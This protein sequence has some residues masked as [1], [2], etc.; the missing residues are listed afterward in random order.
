MSWLDEQNMSEQEKYF[1]RRNDLEI[2]RNQ[3]ALFRFFLKLL[4][5]FFGGMVL[6]GLI[7]FIG[8]H[9]Y[10]FTGAIGGFLGSKIAKKIDKNKD[11]SLN[12]RIIIYLVF[13][14]IFGFIFSWSGLL[15]KSLFFPNVAL[16]LDLYLQSCKEMFISIKNYF[17]DF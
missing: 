6:I 4:P 12:K 17:A 1:Q 10:F 13:I 15:L 2:M 14:S 11:L 7:L 9:L 16:I 3:W 8:V 5:F